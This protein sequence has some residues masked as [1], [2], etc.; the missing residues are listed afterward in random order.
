[1]GKKQDLVISVLSDYGLIPDTIDK[2]ASPTCKSRP[3]VTFRQKNHILI[4][5]IDEHAHKDRDQRKEFNRM[6]DIIEDISFTQGNPI[7]FLRYNPDNNDENS[8][9]LLI[10]HIKNIINHPVLYD[11]L[12][13]LYY[14]PIDDENIIPLISREVFQ[15][16]WLNIMT[17]YNQWPIKS[18]I[19][20]LTRTLICDLLV[21]PPGI[22]APIIAYTIA[23]QYGKKKMQK[24]NYPKVLNLCQAILEEKNSKIEIN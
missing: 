7:T 18:R 22:Q 13:Y 10:K 5:E 4:L 23:I 2:P 16:F 14:N 1:M 12:M 17:I 19:R 15:G 9:F 6:Y 11:S 3:D 8:L 20:Q 24:I 21:T